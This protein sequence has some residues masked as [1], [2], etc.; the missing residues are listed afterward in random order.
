MRQMI[1]AANWKMNMTLAEGASFLNDFKA[2]LTENAKEN[3]TIVLFPP[4]ILLDQLIKDAENSPIKIGGQNCHHELNGAYTGE[5][6]APMIRST[7]S[8]Y[9]IIGHSERRHYFDEQEDV[10]SK[11]VGMALHYGLTPIY[12]CGETLDQRN[13]HQQEKVVSEQLEKGLFDLSADEFGKV[14]IAYEPIWAIGTGETATPEQA[15]EMHE[16]IRK[17]IEKKYGQSVAED[18]PVLYGGSVKPNN[19][20][21]LF[22]QTHI[23]GALV[24]GASLN[25]ADFNEIIR[26]A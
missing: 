24:G 9:V 7:G 4:F 2:L 19:A 25:P 16:F 6:S 20:P 3:K 5:V 8:E 17:T 21:E 18:T 13:Q 23:D 1:L 14:V 11:K 10:L 26:S 22:A 12:C 15:N